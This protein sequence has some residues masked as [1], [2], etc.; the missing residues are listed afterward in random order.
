MKV[1]GVSENAVRRTIDLVSEE[2][3]ASNLVVKQG[4][5]DGRAFRFTLTVLKASKPGGRRGRNG[6]K[7]AAACWH[8][9]RDVMK[10]IFALNP[11]ARVKTRYSDYGGRSDFE[12][13]YPRSGLV[14]VG[15]S[16]EPV[17]FADA[18]ECGN[19]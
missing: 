18:C 3:Y 5:P 14:N 9:H 7:I 15:W 16:F 13:N 12:C 1:W 11:L 6:R 10:M 17:C 2:K 19:S 8:C 4:G